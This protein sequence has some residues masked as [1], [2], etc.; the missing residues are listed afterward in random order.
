MNDTEMLREWLKTRNVQADADSGNAADAFAMLLRLMAEVE[1]YGY[2]R[3]WNNQ[4]TEL[5]RSGDHTAILK[6][7]RT[8]TIA[9][10]VNTATTHDNCARAELL[11]RMAWT[12]LEAD[13][14]QSLEPI[15]G[16]I[17]DL[18]YELHGLQVDSSP[19]EETLKDAV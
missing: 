3:A 5:I 13:G 9:V 19:T 11:T 14:P 2:D 4:V 10:V 17:D 8:I 16:V 18:Y 15:A 1:E 6:A 7:Y 12:C